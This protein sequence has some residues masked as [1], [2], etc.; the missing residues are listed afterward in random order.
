MNIEI[1]KKKETMIG[2]ISTEKKI[3]GKIMTKKTM[4][5]MIIGKIMMKMTVILKTIKLE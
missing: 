5:K 3:I 2:K 1:K 4:K